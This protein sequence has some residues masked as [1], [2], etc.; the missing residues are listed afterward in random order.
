MAVYAPRKV[1]PRG[2]GKQAGGGWWSRLVAWLLRRKLKAA[3]FRQPPMIS[4]MQ[5]ALKL[6]RIARNVL[7]TLVL[8]AVTAAALWGAVTLMLRS[9]IFRVTDIRISGIRV[10][11]QRQILDLAGLQQ[12]DS[13]LHFNARDAMARIDAHPWV[14]Q[15]EITTRWPSAV[16]IRITEFQPFALVNL[17]GTKEKPLRYLNQSGQLFAEVAQGQELDYPVI[18]GVRAAEDLRGDRFVKDS[19]A[20]Q[21]CQLLRMAARGN[22]I[23][24]IQG[25]SEVHV[26]PERGLVLYLVDQPFPI[27]FGKDRLQTKYYRLVR[28]LEQLY[29]KKQVDAVKEI[30]MDY[31]DD[32][33]LVTGPK[34]DG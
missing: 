34:F 21:A 28:V 18:T 10:T 17:Q 27:Y 25:I 1:T 9:N 15:V 20:D 13:L 5:R 12:G 24:P 29:A 33:V 19:P 3:P 22:A 16:E 23:L 26:D 2:G 6:K 7:L 14:E 32:K 31:L 4:G 11:S 30:R 8:A